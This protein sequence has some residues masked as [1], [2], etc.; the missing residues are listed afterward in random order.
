MRSR[1][2]T[3]FLIILMVAGL[4]A[5]RMQAQYSPD[6]D[7]QVGPDPGAQYPDQGQ[8]PGP[9]PG[10]QYPAPGQQTAPPS[11]YPPPGPQAAPPS[12]YPQSGQ[13]P[14]PPGGQYPPP[15]P[16]YPYPQPGYPPQQGPQH[17]PQ[18]NGQQSNEPGV[19]RISLTHG[20][21]STQRGDSGDWSAAALNAPMMAGDKISTGDNSRAEVQLDYADV[22]RLGDHAQAQIA[23]LT[24]SDIQVQL[25]QGMAS[26]TAFKD[27]EARVEIDTPNLAIHPIGN[28][29]V[30]RIL[31]NSPEESQVIVRKGEAEISTPGGSVRVA[32]GQLITVRGTG[33][34]AQYQVADAPARDD[35]DEW[36]NDRD[37]IIRDAGA[38]RHTDRYYTGS[39]DL[40][41]Y[42]N[43][44]TVPDYGSVWIP[45]VAPG[46]V[47]YRAG[48]WV[49]EPYW[50]WT[51]VSYEPWGW[52]P[53]HYGR[54]FLYG[55][56]WAWWPGPVV[57][58]GFGYPYRPIWAP[59][60][61]SFF[62][63]GGGGFGV[64]IGFGFGG[65]GSFGWLPI[66][67]GDRFFPWW[68]GYRGRFGEVG[69]GGFNGFHGGW[70]PLHA[71]DRFSNVRMAMNNERMRNAFST[72]PAGRFGQGR[73]AATPVSR[74]ML[75]GAHAMTGNLPV[76]PTRASL[77]ASG[78]AASPSTTRGGAGHFFG[79]RA[80]APQSFERQAAQV[81][82]AIQRDGRFA[83]GQNNTR[84]A[85]NTQGPMA[86][87]TNR[88]GG[89]AGT[90]SS[91]TSS[92]S[93]A[94]REGVAASDRGARATSGNDG[95]RRFGSAPASSRTGQT[96]QAQN[97]RPAPYGNASRPGSSTSARPN[98]PPGRAAPSTPNRGESLQRYTPQPRSAAPQPLSRSPAS[99]AYGRSGYGN[100]GY[101]SSAY[102][103]GAYGYGGYS[104][105]TLNMSKPIVTPR[106]S[107]AYGGGRYPSGGGYRGS[108]SGGGHSA[109]SG[110]GHS[111]GGG[112]PSGGGHSRR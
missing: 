6:Q 8:Q 20:E 18:P 70:G 103:R 69:I 59:A 11:Q 109:P 48:N 80:A 55:N 88:Y 105:P 44:T 84:T 19:A 107:G 49:W 93:G 75:A 92:P 60:Y 82:E 104:R 17:P 35:W 90:P 62:G 25:A 79:S 96:P 99:S 77:S 27:G 81:H 65:F 4:G 41:A 10:E 106:S 108:P 46:W 87:D 72:V 30:Y 71:G 54:W 3:A 94:N 12:Q 102:G 100:G 97:S 83:A 42:G 52:A 67:P 86:S 43:W 39:E 76:T 110:G 89:S 16:R 101:G 57:G 15:G 14:P 95:W 64:G 47:P 50:G 78:R 13:Y 9:A 85:M 23:T 58:V 2:A 56:S 22:F 51:W 31:V 68:G 28:E 91:R 74:E 111:S 21:V 45:A 32:K 112:H 53:Y 24:R 1:L 34:D 37:H 36:N 38:W 63:F 29:G 5:T 98:D 61:V 40:D 66:G 26:Y 73:V 33:N 7:Q